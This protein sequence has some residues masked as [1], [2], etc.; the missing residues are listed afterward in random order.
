VRTSQLFWKD[1]PEF[2]LLQSEV[3][4]SQLV[5]HNSTASVHPRV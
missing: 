2:C 5:S 3:N 4:A 1:F